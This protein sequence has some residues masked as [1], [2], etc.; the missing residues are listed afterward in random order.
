MKRIDWIFF[1]FCLVTGI[2]AGVISVMVPE[3]GTMAVSPY[4]WVLIAVA[5]FE[6][7]AIYLRG[8]E[9]GPPLTMKTRVLGFCLGIGAMVVI[10]LGGG[11]A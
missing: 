3:S 8:F 6:T 10:R 11:V 9:Y 7:V 1:G 2:A 4:F 5:L